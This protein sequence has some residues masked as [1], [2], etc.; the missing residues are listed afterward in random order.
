MGTPNAPAP[1]LPSL[2][3]AQTP[4]IVRVLAFALLAALL[5]AVP[6]LAVSPWTQTV[7]G[8]G[9]AIA[10]NPVQRA[11]FVISPIEGRVKKWHV[12]EGDRVKAGQLLVEL[13]DNDPLILERLREQ[14]TLAL[15]RLALADGRVLDQQ[16]R[17]EFVKG[18]REV[19]VAEAG[20]RVEQT[21]AQVLVVKQ[22]LQQS[23]FNL[24]REELAYERLRKLSKSS[25][26][27][28]VSGD[29]VEEAERK[30]D[31]AKAQVPLVEARLKLAERTLDGAKAQREAT[32]KR[33]AGLIQTEEAAVKAAKSE[34]ASVRQQYNMIRTQVERQSNQR[35]HA[36]VDGVI[37]RVLANAE[38]GG[39]LVRAGERL[40]VL[41]PDVKAVT[42]DLTGDYHPGI[43]AELTIDGNDLPLVRVGDRVLLQFE[44]WAA[45]QFAAYPEAAAGTFEGRVYLVDPT[46]D[47]VGGGFRVLVEPAPGA[48]WPDEQFLRQGVRAQGWIVLNEVR[49]GYEVWRLLNGFPPVREVKT[50]DKPARRPFGPVTK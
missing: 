4:R 46:A 48:A 19:L 9:R 35:I 22:E 17:L 8:T 1:A 39:Q 3:A 47:G 11:Q 44:G 42:P 38:A 15:Q 49:L 32:D 16:N 45:V 29:A 13:V 33:T 12:V 24:R 25:V 6:A 5:L 28:V 43:V 21:E 30:R 20:Y 2:E 26:G 27:E 50:Q 7:H 31:L 40:A 36:A 18:E 41:V 14:E 23:A 10:F 37:F 34:Q